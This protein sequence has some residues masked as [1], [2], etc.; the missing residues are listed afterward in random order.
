MKWLIK[1]RRKME[2]T[3]H[4][5]IEPVITGCSR[6]DSPGAAERQ[7]AIFQRVFPFNSYY[8]EPAGDK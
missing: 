3:H 6:Y 7:V 1:W 8:V 5:T 4:R 2:T